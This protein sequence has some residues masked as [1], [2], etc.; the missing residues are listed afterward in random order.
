MWPRLKV[1][2][3]TY[4]TGD[5]RRPGSCVGK[6]L[7]LQAELVRGGMLSLTLFL[8]A[9]PKPNEEKRDRDRTYQRHQGIQ[10]KSPARPDTVD[11]I[12]RHGDYHGA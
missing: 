11:D 9:W 2:Y 5:L 10:G 3:V 7:T 4:K 12:L 8:P 6:A 1:G